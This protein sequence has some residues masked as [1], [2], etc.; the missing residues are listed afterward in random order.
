MKLRVKEKEDEK[1]SEEISEER[2]I[3]DENEWKIIVKD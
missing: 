2:E 3:W 1:I